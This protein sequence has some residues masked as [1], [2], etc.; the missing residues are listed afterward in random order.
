MDKSRQRKQM[1]RSNEQYIVKSKRVWWREVIVV[2]FTFLVWIY[3][4]MVIIFFMEPLLP[5][6]TEYSSIFRSAFRMTRLD[7]RFF[8]LLAVG[9]YVMIYLSLYLW[10]YYNKRRFGSL[11][12]RKNPGMTTK[13]DLL[14]LDMIDEEMYQQLQNSKSI[15]LQTNPVRLKEKNLL[16]HKKE[17][18][19][20]VKDSI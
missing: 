11:T 13:E 10:S 17:I 1:K 4:L 9:V 20:V 19:N 14:E 15:V 5:F 12:R 7:I 3:C 8:L 18:K 6:E 2:F 16:Q